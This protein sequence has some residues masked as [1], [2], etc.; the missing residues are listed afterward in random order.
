MKTL[1]FGDVDTDDGSLLL[2]DG[3][4]HGVQGHTVVVPAHGT[5][6]WERCLDGFRPAGKAGSGT[7]IPSAEEQALVARL[8]VVVRELAGQRFHQPIQYGPP[9]W[10]WVI[11]VREGSV[12]D[13]V[14]GGEVSSPGELSP[15]SVRDALAWL[16]RRVDELSE[17]Q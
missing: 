4:I 13:A 8:R 1:L 7:F 15:E 16:R 3:G 9:R 11:A 6:R 14:E 10:S 12:L 2:M 17:A 5:W